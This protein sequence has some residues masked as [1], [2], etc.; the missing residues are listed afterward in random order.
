MNMT[1]NTN[2]LV[3]YYDS[4]K[5]ATGLVL[6]VEDRRIRLLTHTGK[7]T[8]M[9][10]N[11][12]LNA[13][14]EMP[15]DIRSS[16]GRDAIVS[17]LKG[18]FATREELKA[19]INLQEIWEVVGTELS[20]IDPEELS[21]LVFG[22]NRDFNC[23]ASL[24]RA[25]FEDR[26][27]FKMRTDGIEVVAPEKVEQALLQRDKEHQKRNFLRICADFLAALKSKQ[28]SGAQPP[29]EGLVPVLE[30]A[31]M[32]GREWESSS[33]TKEIF[34]L[35]GLGSSW[36][37]FRALVAMGQWS[38]DENIRL[39]AERVPVEFSVEAE[40]EACAKSATRVTEKRE[41]RTG[42]RT[43]TI[44]SSSTR[45]VDD[46]ISIH[47]QGDDLIVGIHIT[48][49][50][51]CIEYGSLLDLEIRHRA[52][53]IYLPDMTIPM[54]P[55]DLSERAASLQMGVERPTID[56]MITLDDRLKI[57]DFRLSQSFIKVSQRLTYEEADALISDPDSEEALMF[58]VARSMRQERL[59]AGAL[60]FKDPECVLYVTEDGSV[61]VTTR[62]RE[63]PSQQ[64]VSE[65][66]IL[67]NALF[68][69]T[70]KENKVSAIFRS[71]P[72]PQEK[73]QLGEQYDPV[74]SYQ[75][76]RLLPRGEVGLDP[77]PHFSLGV[78]A[79]ST[80]S[81]PLRRYTDL[82]VQRQLKSI[83]NENSRP[84]DR[85]ELERILL[86]VSYPL[87][88]ASLME[89]D[90]NRYFLLKH[91]SQRKGEE[92][93]AVVLQRFPRFYLVHMKDFV[94]NAAL[95]V[96]NSVTLNQYDRVLVQVD[97][98]KPRADVLTLSLVKLL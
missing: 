74:E 29:P 58:A 81:S 46:A 4:R 66:M 26:V 70:L 37:P 24:I 72:P 52:T 32:L 80:A 48:D 13:V 36:D 9:S 69:R 34:S 44:D 65:M 87:E 88:R 84:L 71:Q 62:E 3:D 98:A 21:E 33:V 6:E 56:L 18:I 28:V 14:R 68:A 75:N 60:I 73:I 17:A 7:E 22:K 5:I 45:D 83:L 97:K 53:S 40:E 94:F 12:I 19:T 43:I 1:L 31:A 82:V 51:S 39:R 96:P 91:L 67:A 49:V 50:D 59:D 38:E 89:R 35:A 63:T 10:A 92:F 54:L 2:D 77:A 23:T 20:E 27:Y 8:R 79:Y 15:K 11:R 61:K 86:E 90:R 64:L 95:H 42:L 47:R 41:D 30:Q 76:K 16:N 85:S 25:I 57:R 78:D 93:E 55:L